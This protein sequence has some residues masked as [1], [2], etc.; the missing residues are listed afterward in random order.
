ME[1]FNCNIRF[2]KGYNLKILIQNVHEKIK[3]G[4]NFAKG[5]NLKVHLQN[6]HEIENIN[7]KPNVYEPINDIMEIIGTLRNTKFKCKICEKE[8][9]EKINFKMHIKMSIEDLKK[10][11]CDDYGKNF[12]QNIGLKGHIT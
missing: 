5:F 4:K 6:V 2:A 1:N 3:I 8:I 11:K 7:T 12:T 10:Y 9:I